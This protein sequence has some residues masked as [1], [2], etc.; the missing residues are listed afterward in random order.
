MGMKK[1][2]AVGFEDG[3]PEAV[4]VDRLER[5]S[6]SVE[7]QLVE[8]SGQDTD[9]ESLANDGEQLSSDVQGLEQT[10]DVVTQ[11]VEDGGMDE[12]AARM[13]DIAV[14]SFASKW[15]I[16][17]RKVAG[18]SF[19]GGNRVRATKVAY[20]SV[21]STLKSAYR[22]VVEWIKRMWGKLKDWWI[23]YFNAGK[24]IVSRAEKLTKVLEKG[25]G[26]KRDNKI[27]GSWVKKLTVDG[28]FD[29]SY[30]PSVEKNADGAVRSAVGV[31][32]GAEKQLKLVRDSNGTTVDL[33]FGKKTN[34]RF[35]NL[36]PKDATAIS[37]ICGFNNG[38]LV[39]W[40]MDGIEYAQYITPDAEH[41]DKDVATPDVTAIRQALKAADSIGS[42]LESDIK[43]WREVQD[44]H[45]SLGEAAE[46]AADHDK[47]LKGDE[48]AAAKLAVRVA[49]Q[50]V[51]NYVAL[52]AFTVDQLKSGGS[53]LLSYAEA[54]ID[55]YEPVAD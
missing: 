53:G 55:A 12:S 48:L 8:I 41:I 18:E 51:K 52:R 5:P 32:T 2:W 46:T 3:T 36:V 7:T 45:K 10:A 27:G 1:G 37:A 23:G 43:D 31:I 21:M 11:A 14:E 44:K 26:K 38:Y 42:V 47:D 15:G 34:K 30:G 29:P 33:D 22:K 13:V 50:A 25:L 4:D 9:I 20:E 39:K 49:Q 6:E 24:S 28:K 54:A 19:T 40:T 17:Y 35:E 16:S